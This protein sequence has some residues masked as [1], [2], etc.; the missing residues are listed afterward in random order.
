MK[1][2]VLSGQCGNGKDELANHLAS[3][4]NQTT[5]E[6][7][8]RNAFAYGVKKIYCETFGVTIDFLEKW[9]RIDE[10]PP[11][12]QMPVRKALQFIGDGFRQ[13]KSNIWIELALRDEGKNK[14]I[15]D[16]RY[17]NEAIATRK[18]G[19]YNILV[20]RPGHENNDPNPSE[21]QI[22]VVV[23]WCKAN[24]STSGPIITDEHPM[25]LYDFFMIND[26]TIKDLQD[27]ITTLL[28]PQIMNYIVV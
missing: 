18:Q 22:K 17:F 21:S 28:L 25:A 9:K 23:D 20:W 13:I 8:T 15:S 24:M 26:G 6:T 14:I 1:A 2:I 19:G 5:A 7:W 11:G 12:M 4:L 16:G 27:R 3:I 10:A